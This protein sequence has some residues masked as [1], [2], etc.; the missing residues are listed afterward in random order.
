LFER[1]L[2]AS[3]DDVGRLSGTQSLVGSR[4]LRRGEAFAPPAAARSAHR[5]YRARCS[6]GVDLSLGRM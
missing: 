6:S 2:L 4:A 3:V 1:G 5:P